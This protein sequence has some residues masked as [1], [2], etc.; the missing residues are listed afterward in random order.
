M[1]AAAVRH[2][3]RQS[4]TLALPTISLAT[5]AAAEQTVPVTATKPMSSQSSADVPAKMD[6]SSPS[7]PPTAHKAHSSSTSPSAS[8]S[9]DHDERL[10]ARDADLSAGEQVDTAES[11]ASSVSTRTPQQQSQTEVTGLGSRAT[12]H[13]DSKCNKEDAEETPKS[14]RKRPKRCESSETHDVK[15][16]NG[17]SKALAHKG[18]GK[19]KPKAKPKASG[20]H[21]TGNQNPNTGS[22]TTTAPT[23]PT[24]VVNIQA[25]S[26]DTRTE[27]DTDLSKSKSI[28][29]NKTK[30]K[31]KSS[32]T[33]D[34]P[35]GLTKQSLRTS[36]VLGQS[37][38][39]IEHPV[40]ADSRS[41]AVKADLTK[42][43][44]SLRANSDSSQPPETSKMPRM[45]EG[46]DPSRLFCRYCGRRFQTT[47]H[48]RR[49][50][51][52]H[53][54]E[55]P[56]KCRVCGKAFNQRGNRNV[57]ERSAHGHVQADPHHDSPGVSLA[58]RR[59]EVRPD[60]SGSGRT[61]NGT[62]LGHV[63]SLS[64]VAPNPWGFSAGA[65][66]QPSGNPANMSPFLI[67]VTYASGWPWNPSM[68][69]LS[70]MMPQTNMMNWGA[71]P[72]ASASSP[73]AA[74]A[75][76]PAIA[77]QA[78][79]MAMMQQWM[80]ASGMPSMPSTATNSSS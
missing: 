77:N 9:S 14:P 61:D 60:G 15:Q 1:A 53:S 13:Q 25:T 46:K 29:Q 69:A 3:L 38:T 33:T 47:A 6:A 44:D 37:T 56:F 65:L 67:P 63:P 28:S 8:P 51:R 30:T 23:P 19:S 68:A 5:A 49:H 57:H 79:L 22:T 41:T 78:N 17:P 59:P 80:Q 18:R 10:S 35:G 64:M 26:V 43:T 27:T 70:M 24:T 73:T 52:I 36:P 16:A 34:I 40:L 39:F 31:P 12:S 45:V 48:V 2:L 50:E 42:T 4:Q 62:A 54:G 66:P 21:A 32:L 72:A 75:T 74:A 76:S 7:P 71:M 11:P 55:K 20:S 58:D